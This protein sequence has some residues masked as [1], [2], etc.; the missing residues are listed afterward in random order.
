MMLWCMQGGTGAIWKK[1]AALLPADKQR[2][3]ATIT[4]MDPAAKVITLKVGLTCARHMCLRGR[5]STH[6]TSCCCSCARQD[7]SKIK[8]NKLLTT[9][10]LDITL[11]WLGK[12]DLAKRL[13]YSSSH[14]IGLGLR[15]QNPH[16]TKVIHSLPLY[17][18]PVLLLSFSLPSSLFQTTPIFSPLGVLACSYSPPNPSAGCTTRRTT[19]PSTAARSSPTTPRKMPRRTT[20]SCP[21]C[22]TA[23]SPCPCRQP[24]RSR[25][26]GRTGRSCSK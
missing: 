25:C 16:D 4:G 17:I 2:Y 9:I 6:T 23:T 22:A 20:P 5:S 14:I 8:Y 24:R 15:G 7:G 12:A 26:R 1:V 13:T 10:P 18:F 19:A 11:T 3:N 21:L